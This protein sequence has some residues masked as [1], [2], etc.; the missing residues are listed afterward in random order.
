MV[1]YSRRL[2]VFSFLVAFGFLALTAC[3]GGYSGAPTVVASVGGTANPLVAQFAVSAPC[4]GQAMV[5]FGLDTSYGRSTSWYPVSGDLLRRTMILVA[6]MRASTTYHM[7]STVQ[8][9]TQT[10]NSNDLTFTTG[11]L[12]SG[13]T[14]PT[15]QVSRPAGL[16][17]SAEAPGIES[18]DSTNFSATNLIQALF[19]NRDGDPIW[20]YA[21]PTGYFPFNIKMLPNGHLIVSATNY[22]ATTAFLRE[23]DLAGNTIRE[24][25]I[26]TLQQKVKNA[27]FDFYPSYFHHD[28]IPLANGH[29]IVLVNS[30]KSFT[31]LPGYPG[32]TS[33]QGDQII[34]LD[35]NW[36]PVWAWNS[37]DH[38][39]VNRHLAGLPDWT[40]SNG[41]VYLPNDG[42]LL[43]SMRHQS[44]I[45]K[46]ITT[47]APGQAMCFG[48]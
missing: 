43:L 15:V 6:G 30:F 47:M 26:P 39:D 38:L 24:L 1:R 8:C 40:H 36:N 25:D 14:F 17:K 12:P 10:G 35:Q 11:P 18:I 22:G 44:W 48:S 45:L 2:A 16:P 5:E 46:S 37:F 41:L 33:V 20:Y 32:T 29:L 3:G 7:R 4:T 9:A 21:V 13:V 42:N 31:D 28:L 19:T 34:D 23:I 27:G